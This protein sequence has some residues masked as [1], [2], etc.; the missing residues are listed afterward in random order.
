[1]W[2]ISRLYHPAPVDVCAG[3]PGA[4]DAAAAREYRTLD[5]EQIGYV[6]EG[7]LDHKLARAGDEARVKLSGRAE[8]IVPLSELTAFYVSR[9]RFQMRRFAR[10]RGQGHVRD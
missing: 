5:I 3:A 8:A 2:P 6:Y 9:S 10:R 1:M 4:R 7:L